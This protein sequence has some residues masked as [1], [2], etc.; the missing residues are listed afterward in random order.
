MQAKEGRRELIK[1]IRPV[2]LKTA[3]IMNELEKK[4]AKD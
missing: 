1:H 4:S 3:R 2:L